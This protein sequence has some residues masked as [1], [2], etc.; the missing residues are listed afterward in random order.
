MND[1]TV[2]VWGNDRSGGKSSNVSLDNVKYI[3][4]N[5]NAFA[6]LKEDGT[7]EVCGNADRGGQNNTTGTLSDIKTSYSLDIIDKNIPLTHQK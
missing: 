2:R 4:S 6:A 7:V 3:Y 5:D 1:G